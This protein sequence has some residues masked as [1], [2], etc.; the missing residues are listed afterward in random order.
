MKNGLKTAGY[1]LIIGCALATVIYFLG[2]FGECFQ[3]FCNW[4]CID[5]DYQL[6]YGSFWS[7]NSYFN[8]VTVISSACSVIGFI[9]GLLSEDTPDYE[10][11]VPIQV[12]I[13]V[14]LV[15]IFLAMKFLFGCM[16]YACV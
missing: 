5:G 9:Y 13:I 3:C 6:R 11:N 8:Y 15:V 4:D 2:S 10:G 16:Y 12:W 14:I 7:W 1:G